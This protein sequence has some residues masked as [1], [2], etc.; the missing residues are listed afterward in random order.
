MSAPLPCCIRTRPII[1]NATTIWTAKSTKKP[2]HLINPLICSAA[3]CQKI[4]QSSS[5]DQTTI[6]ITLPKQFLHYPVSHTPTVQYP[7]THLPQQDPDP[8][9][10]A[11]SV[12]NLLRFRK[13]S[14]CSN[15]PYRLVASTDEAK[16]ENTHMPPPPE[17]DVTTSTVAPDSRSAKS[18]LMHKMVTPTRFC[19]PR[20]IKFATYD[21]PND[22]PTINPA[23]VTH[24]LPGTRY[25]DA[26]QTTYAG[27]AQ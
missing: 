21:A 1:A 23:K 2:I 24:G 18:F 17:A 15:S 12:V 9:H 27:M 13:L 5:T 25:R 4:T 8:L 19:P 10:N 7:A 11:E 20:P 14:P 3:N 22:Q 6:D 26:H 16:P